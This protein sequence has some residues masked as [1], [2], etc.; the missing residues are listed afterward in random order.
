MLPVST[1][2]QWQARHAWVHLR[3]AWTVW[4]CGG[5][6][7]STIPRENIYKC[8]CEWGFTES[9]IIRVDEGH[10]RRDASS[11]RWRRF[12][13]HRRRKRK[14]PNVRFVCFRSGGEGSQRVMH[15]TGQ[16][17]TVRPRR[18]LFSWLVFVYGSHTGAINHGIS[19]GTLFMTSFTL[20]FQP[21]AS[22]L[23]R[24]VNLHSR[25]VCCARARRRT[26]ERRRCWSNAVVLL[27]ILIEHLSP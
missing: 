14:Y 3:R 11:S 18:S 19:E 16:P 22:F 20:H 25:S 1:D 5:N 23:I 7:S 13:Q 21:W 6:N 4:K 15:H 9:V 24:A 10:R 17:L 12:A 2:T 27:K 26:H 8:N